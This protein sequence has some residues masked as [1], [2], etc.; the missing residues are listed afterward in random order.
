MSEPSF[1]QGLLE[2]TSQADRVPNHPKSPLEQGYSLSEALLT[3]DHRGLSCF[4]SYDTRM[5]RL[6][7]RWGFMSPHT[8]VSGST[9]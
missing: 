2:S 6:E 1:G 9:I 5:E 4:F 8:V 7:W 3:T